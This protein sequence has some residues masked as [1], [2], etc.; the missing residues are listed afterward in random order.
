M[1]KE[2]IKIRKCKLSDDFYQ[3][4]RLLYL[5][6]IYIYPYL[7][8]N[9]EVLGSKLMA[10]YAK[11]NTVFNYKNIKVAVLDNKIARNSKAFNVPINIRRNLK[12]SCILITVILGFFLLS[13]KKGE[14]N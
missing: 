6:D 1:K 9:D 13:D 4:G 3:V 12:F 11:A 5:T 8:N 2:K 7:S 14:L 10:E